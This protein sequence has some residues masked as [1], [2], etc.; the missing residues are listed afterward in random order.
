MFAWACSIGI[1]LAACPA[2]LS[3]LAAS[4]ATVTPGMMYLDDDDDDDDDDD[5]VHARPK[6][7]PASWGWR[8][9]ASDR[10][11]GGGGG[12]GGTGR[13]STD[14]DTGT[15][16]DDDDTDNVSDGAAATAAAHASTMGGGFICRCVRVVCVGFPW[17][18]VKKPWRGALGRFSL[19]FFLLLDSPSAPPPHPHPHP[20]HLR[21]YVQVLRLLLCT[22]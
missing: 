19:P 16:D 12:G 22:A 8:R 20:H 7:G 4:M 9:G 17:L 1:V 18:G 10:G 21:P 6:G 14:T 11:G 5:V 2:S 3:P 13:G 15:D